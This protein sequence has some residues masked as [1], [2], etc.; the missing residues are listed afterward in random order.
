MTLYGDNRS[1]NMH[2]FQSEHNTADETHHRTITVSLH[3]R[4]KESYRMMMPDVKGRLCA[5]NCLLHCG[6]A[7]NWLSVPNTPI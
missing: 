4:S 3:A 1:L 5:V 6:Q 7:V 2:S